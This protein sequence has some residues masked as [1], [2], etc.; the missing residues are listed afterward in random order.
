M[1]SH[2]YWNGFIYNAYT[3]GQ[4]IGCYQ[5]MMMVKALVIGRMIYYFRDGF[6][7]CN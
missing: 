7:F 2:Q 4:R 6:M 5:L 1:Y 3:Y